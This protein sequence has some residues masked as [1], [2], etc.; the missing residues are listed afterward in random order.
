MSKHL[1]SGHIRNHIK[2]MARVMLFLAL[3]GTL[4]PIDVAVRAQDASHTFPE[5]GKTVAGRF[6]GYW[7]THGALA[8]QGFPIS[9]EMQ[10]KSDLDG[11]TYTTQYFERAVFEYHPENKPPND[12]LLSQLGTF[13]LRQ[14]YPNPNQL[15][16]QQPN[17]EPGSVLVPETGKRMGGK[18]KEYWEAHGG[19]AQQ[20]FPISEEMKE[21]NPTDG[22]DYLVQYFE[23]S[24]MEI[25]PEYAGTPNEVLLSL[26]GN[27]QYKEK[28]NPDGTPKVSA[29]A[30]AVATA[31]PRATST[32]EATATPE[33][34]QS[35]HYD[36]LVPGYKGTELIGY[37]G[38]QTLHFKNDDKNRVFFSSFDTVRKAQGSDPDKL[39]IP[40]AVGGYDGTNARTT[41]IGMAEGPFNAGQDIVFRISHSVD[42]FS[43][44]PINDERILYSGLIHETGDL[45]PYYYKLNKASGQLE[46]GIIAVDGKIA[47]GASYSD[48]M[49]SIINNIGYIRDSAG[50]PDLIRWRTENSGGNRDNQIVP[51]SLFDTYNSQTHTDDSVY[52]WK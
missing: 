42:G 29:T 35:N 14:R 28:Y 11:K 41:N 9:Q 22:K 38:S 31:T 52:I 30:T 49:A 34:L 40:I 4:A 7:N 24:V 21:K 12:V 50:H 36:S 3:V 5:T 16:A 26:L 20:G 33:A 19:L 8:Q 37:N 13:Q 48:M 47:S 32:P 25:H 6:L 45:H 46:M 1:I 15:P 17:N 51:Y 44:T 39:I 43:S 18:F 27:F 23:R 2:L 10:E